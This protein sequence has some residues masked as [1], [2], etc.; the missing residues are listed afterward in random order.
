MRHRSWPASLR[1]RSIEVASGARLPR[2]RGGLGARTRGH[3]PRQENE[4]RRSPE[5]ISEALDIEDGQRAE[6]CRERSR[7]RESDQQEEGRR[8]EQRA[9]DTTAVDIRHAALNYPKHRREGHRAG[10][11]DQEEQRDHDRD[12]RA[13]SRQ[14]ED[15][16]V[17]PSSR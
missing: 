11:P 4:H 3:R 8:R 5:H 17:D 13:E 10:D 14:V 2:S 15:Q 16:Q 6:R 7:D 9:D 1:A 12:R